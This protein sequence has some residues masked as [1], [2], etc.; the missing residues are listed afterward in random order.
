M[1]EPFIYLPG[2]PGLSFQL[3]QLLCP[4]CLWIQ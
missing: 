1:F 4:D 2:L 3:L